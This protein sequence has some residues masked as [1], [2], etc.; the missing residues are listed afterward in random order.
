LRT[1]TRVGNVGWGI[2]TILGVGIIITYFDRIN[3]SVAT[4]IV[5]TENHRAFY[6]HLVGP[7]IAR[8]FL[9]LQCVLCA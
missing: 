2:A 5:H 7:V 6:K 3:F 4:S 9:V 8:G 1:S